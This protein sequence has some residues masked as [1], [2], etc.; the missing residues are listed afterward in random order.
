MAETGWPSSAVDRAASRRAALNMARV[1]AAKYARLYSAVSPP[2]AHSAATSISPIKALTRQLSLRTPLRCSVCSSQALSP[3]RMSRARADRAS[4]DKVVSAES[5]AKRANARS[6][7]PRTVA[8][9]VL[10]TVCRPPGRAVLP[11]ASSASDIS[12]ICRSAARAAERSQFIT[13]HVVL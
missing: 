10:G 3:S 12:T 8:R 9:P 6:T 4:G 11:P 2:R 5:S 7:P 13:G 1:S